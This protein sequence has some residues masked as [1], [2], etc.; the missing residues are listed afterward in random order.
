MRRLS[1]N[2][3]AIIILDVRAAR[4]AF[5]PPSASS[6]T[7]RAMVPSAVPKE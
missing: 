6:E 4:K 3:E 1:I 2:E 7:V 5:D